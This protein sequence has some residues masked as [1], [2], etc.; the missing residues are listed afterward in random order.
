MTTQPGVPDDPEPGPIE[1]PCGESI[2]AGDLHLGMRELR[3]DC[4]AAHAVVLDP[5]PPTRFLPTS[6]AEVLAETLATEGTD[7]EEFDTVALMGLLMDA[8]PERIVT[9]DA[10]EDGTT[11]YA[12]AWIAEFDARELHERVVET[13]LGVM[14]EAV[15]EAGNED[16]TA[17]FTDHRS[18]FDVG[19]FVAEYREVRDFEDEF[20][21]P[22]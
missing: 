3:C 15:T 21:E 11:G 19:E 18:E 10:A 9:H 17:A 1:L 2:T 7:G 6:V 20:D 22:A 13:V 16:A 12:L 8:Y 4:G 5:H 14:A